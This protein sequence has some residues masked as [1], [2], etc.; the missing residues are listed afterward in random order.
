MLAKAKGL[1]YDMDGTIIDNMSFHIQVWCEFL[2]TLGVT[3][4]PGIFHHDTAGKTNA[5]IFGQYIGSDLTNEQL[6]QY[7]HRKESLYRER[8]KP[9]MKPV[10]GFFDWLKMSNERGVKQAL[11]TAANYQNIAYVLN[12]IRPP[13]SFD[14]IVSAEDVSNGKPHPDIFL[15]SAEQ[16]KLRPEECIVFEDSVAGIEAARRAGMKVVVV[17]T[18]LKDEDVAEKEEVLQAISTFRE[19]L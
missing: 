16:L 14:A 12:G 15:E 9:H 10:D 3:V 8:Y 1:L 7:A 13:V 4:E 18:S 11:A 17:T 5:E 6:Q 2:E 19:L